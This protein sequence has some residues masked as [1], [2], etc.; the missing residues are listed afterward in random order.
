MFSKVCL[1]F[2]VFSWGLA[3]PGQVQLPVSGNALP[4]SSK[5]T[6]L[7]MVNAV[8]ANGYRCGHQQM[9][10]V[11]PLTWD[12]RL[13]K[14]AMRHSLDMERHNLLGHN[15][16]DRSTFSARITGAGFTWDRCGENIA[17]G[18]PDE[19]RV[20]EGWLKSPAHCKNIMNGE[21]HSMG[22]ARSGLFWT[23]DFGRQAEQK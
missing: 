7:K 16:S 1:L 23:Q 20:V 8:R 15:G 4:D 6:L 13:E 21:F 2:L 14:A 11:A 12:D 9:P 17:Q 5:A 22:V 10:P 18:Y 19:K 3:S